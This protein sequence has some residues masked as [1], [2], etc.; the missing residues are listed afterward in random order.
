MR[1]VGRYKALTAAER[2][3]LLRAAVLVV[4]IRAA[5]WTLPYRT[6][7]AWVDK[8]R[9]PGGPARQL[10]RRLIHQVAWATGA[11]SRRVP[12][13][14]CLTQALAMQLIL[15]RLGQASELRL[16]VARDSVGKF[17]AHA[18]VEVQGRVVHGGAIPGFN[19]YS[20][21]KEQLTQSIYNPTVSN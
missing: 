2:R 4:A 5:L 14:S 11:V 10:D 7:K 21:L 1:L 20:P 12:G 3:L 19:R 18:W 8:L 17:E 6:T 9:S 16:G 13:A 15:G